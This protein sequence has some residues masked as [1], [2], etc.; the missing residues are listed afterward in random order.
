M[1]SW[2]SR[3]ALLTS[4]DRRLRDRARA[5]AVSPRWFMPI[6]ITASAV[7]RRAAEQRQRQA[8]GVVEVA[9]RSRAR[10]SAPQCARR[11]AASISLTV[12]LPLLPASDDQR[13]RRSARASA[14]RARRAPRA[15]RRPRSAVPASA[16]ARV[17]RRSAAAA[18]RASACATK[19]WPS[20]RSPVSATNRSPGAS[21]RVSV[22]T[23]VKRTLRARARGRRRR[24]R[25]SRCPSCAAPCRE[26]RARDVGI[27]ERRA[28][29]VASPGR[30]RG[31]C[32]RPARRRRAARRRSRR[33]IAARAVELDASSAGCP[34]RECRARSRWRSP[35][36]SSLRG[37]SLVTT[38]RSASVRGDRGPSPAACPGRGRRR[39]RTRRPARRPAATAG[40][41]AVEHLL[42]R[43][44]RVRV[45]DDHQRLRAAAQALHAARRRLERARARRARR[46]SAMPLASST[47]STP[48]RF[49][50]LNVADQRASATSPRPHGVATRQR[51]AVARR[52]STRG[53]GDVGAAEAVGQHAS[54]P[55]ARAVVDQAAGRTR[56]RR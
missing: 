18:P 35:R 11:I 9:A 27:G 50:A 17:A 15:C 16:P 51:D 30:S 54:A 25:R 5:S 55:R 32:R 46:R 19:S 53:R 52:S 26:R 28:H 42:E 3:C 45:V 29:A 24:A 41:S 39:S 23:R 34:C 37:L 6:S 49:D 56:R 4:A 7:R 20:K 48:S 22:V 43:V 38:T 14:R 8:D 40:R 36:G 33:A 1:N 21:A 13:Q 12:V 10:A 44:G 31:P 47:P 2:C